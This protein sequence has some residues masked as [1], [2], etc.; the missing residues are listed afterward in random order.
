[1]KKILAILFVVALSLTAF[2]G[3][4]GDGKKPSGDGSGTS[5]TVVTDEIFSKE[6]VKLVDESGDAVYRVV[7][8]DGD[9]E[10]TALASKVF[11]EYKKA[12]NTKPK[13]VL[14]S[15]DGTDAYE[16]LVGSTN[17]PES[18]QALDYLFGTG[19]GRYDDYIICTIGKKI[20]INAVTNIG[21]A[22]AV[23]YFNANYLKADG[24]A[25]GILYVGVTAGDFKDIPING[26]NIGRFKMIID[27]TS[28]SYLIQV[29]AEKISALIKSTTG[30]L[31]DLENDIDTAESE[32][33]IVIGNSNRPGTP[34]Q[35]NYG[36]D[37]YEIKIS[38]KKVYLVG[39]STYAV[40]V[41]VTEFAKL[42]EKGSLS[43]ANS[44]AGTYTATVAGYDSSSYYKYVWGDEFNQGQLDTTKW[45]MPEGQGYWDNSGRTFV[46]DETT[47]SFSN[48]TM[49][50]R[51]FYDDNGNLYQPFGIKSDDRLRFNK[52]YLELR[53]RIPTAVGVYSSFWGNGRDKNNA[54]DLLEIDIF[55]NLGVA[56]MLQA[57][58]HWWRSEANGGH[59]S[60]DGVVGERRI[61][62]DENFDLRFH[63]IGL[64]WNDTE[65]SFYSDGT[66]YYTQA[67][68]EFEF[69][70]FIN[71]QVCVNAGWEGR[72]APGDDVKWPIEYEVDY[73]RLFQIDGQSF[74]NN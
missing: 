3:C 55:E 27:A 74:V 73:V 44:K 49:T 62:A 2:A 53:A 35:S 19:A 8:S 7:R 20:V 29:E 30:F 57:N 60:C 58:V 16:I 38:G 50:M 9:T 37:D 12:L 5:S 69:D 26:V 72:T 39:G 68:T 32:Y 21:L 13:N 66:L 28:R 33:E 14:D 61:R 6:D 70:K 65:I 22:S 11:S 54:G 40:Q 59:T 52:G 64:F 47:V 34:A 56:N 36:A 18:Q 48:D 31:V 1:M 71:I 43:D 24:V 25:G 15:E 17:R 45:M 10:V 42:L 46:V 63:T 51:I 67:A 23:D 4:G 41:A